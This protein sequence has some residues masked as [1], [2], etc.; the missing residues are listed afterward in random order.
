MKKQRRKHKAE[1]KVRV[2]QEAIHGLKTVSN[3]AAEFD[4]HSVMVGEMDT[5][6]L[7]DGHLIEGPCVAGGVFHN[8][9]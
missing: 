8:Q 2:A 7:Y 4:I 3:I 5:G 9:C 1:F 6:I